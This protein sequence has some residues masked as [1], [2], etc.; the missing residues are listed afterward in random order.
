M[1]DG[2][3]ELGKLRE[4]GVV[5]ISFYY[6]PVKKRYDIPSFTPSRHLTQLEAAFG[7][8]PWRFYSSDLETLRAMAVVD[9]SS[10]WEAIVDAV[11][12]Y[13]EIEVNLES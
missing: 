8:S 7:S 10:F 6:F 3:G 5:S 9:E 13:D 1:Q 2:R 4:G 12:K 11:E